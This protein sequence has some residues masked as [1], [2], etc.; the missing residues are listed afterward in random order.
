MRLAII[1]DTFVPLRTSGAVQLYDLSR[2]LVR[3]GH[4]VT[5]MVPDTDVGSMGY[6]LSNMEG[7]QVCRL[8][9]PRMKDVGYL[10][11]T[12]AEWF[13][14]YA[15]A[16]GLGR[17]PLASVR[18]DGLIWYSPSIFLTPLVKRLQRQSQCRSYL[19]IRD[20]FPEWALD[21]G[22]LRRG[23]AY[24]ILSSVADQQ[25]RVASVIGIQTQGN[26]AYF[27]GHRARWAHKLEV[28]HNWLTAR[29]VRHCRIDMSKTPLAGRVLFVYA[30]NMGAAQGM[31]VLMD[32]AD[33]L[34]DNPRLG[35][36]FVGRGQ[37]YAALVEDAQRRHLNNV[38]FHD[39][40]EPDEVPGLLAQ[41][42]IGLLALDQRHQSHNIPGK[43][44]SYM[45]AG[46]PVLACVNPGNDLVALI[47]Q[48]GV[49]EAVSS[50]KMPDLTAAALRLSS[51]VN[52]GVVP[53]EQRA[54]M[55]AHQMFAA[56]VAAL[57][58]VTKLQSSETI[59]S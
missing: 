30:G 35:F 38:W 13:N 1:A 55:L 26:S 24:R 29:P 46:M 34:V 33:A 17:S 44:L 12:L 9:A 57:Q 47:H 3:Q 22:L 28:L 14:P 59:G 56:D 54:R 48:H 25:F 7:V 18:W 4:Q 23:L 8:R 21:M 10:R 5:V 32:L 6:E 49:G 52:E 36:V 27:Q 15:M 11:R 50:Y 16:F 40:I 45:H 37:G 58:V 42:H 51:A 53:Y 19:I 43:F 39:E 20:I 41:C 2:E 31:Q